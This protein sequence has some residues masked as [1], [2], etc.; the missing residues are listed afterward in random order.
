M[1]KEIEPTDH[2]QNLHD[3]AALFAMMGLLMREG[4]YDL[5]VSVAFNLADEFMRVR[6]DGTRQSGA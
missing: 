1:K 4:P 2:E 5:I 3:M 6:K